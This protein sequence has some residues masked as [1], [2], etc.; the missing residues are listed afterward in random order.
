MPIRR[1]R[2]LRLLWPYVQPMGPWHHPMHPYGPQPG[3]G[4][5]WGWNWGRLSLDEEK[6]YLDDYIE[7]LKEELAAAEEYRKELEEPEES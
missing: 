4:P 6:E 2:R 5:Y 3:G 1:R 7:M